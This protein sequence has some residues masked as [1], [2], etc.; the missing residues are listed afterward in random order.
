M[1]YK[2]IIECEL[3]QDSEHIP[4]LKYV[5]EKIVDEQQDT[6][7]EELDNTCEGEQKTQESDTG[8]VAAIGNE[9]Y[10]ENVVVPLSH[11]TQAKETLQLQVY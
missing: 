2:H 10:E 6:V 3:C 1:T 11:T 9:T 4:E 8:A 7:S 5:K